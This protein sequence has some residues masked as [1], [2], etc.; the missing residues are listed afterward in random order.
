MNKSPSQ[1]LPLKNVALALIFAVLLGP[2][3]LLYSTLWGGIIM[4]MVGFVVVCAKFIVPVILVWLLCCIWSV[5]ATN[6]Y[7]KKIICTSY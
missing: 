7:N 6:R 4:I 1:H 3:G 2:V 5:A